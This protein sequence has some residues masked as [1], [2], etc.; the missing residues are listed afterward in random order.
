M[1]PGSAART[2]SAMNVHD[3]AA[4]GR[5]SRPHRRPAGP[6]AREQPPGP[7]PPG[8]PDQ[9]VGPD[10]P[11]RGLVGRLLLGGL[12]ATASA[13]PLTVLTAL[14][15]SRSGALRDWDTSIVTAVHDQVVVRP[16]LGRVLGWL[17]VVTHPNTVRGATAVLVVGLWRGGHRR[18]AA[19]LAATITLGGALDPLLKDSVERAR[20]VFDHPVALAPGYSFPSGH[21]LNTMLLAAC[22]V[23]LAHGP[24]HGRPLRRAAVWTGAVLLVLVT[25]ADRVGLGVHYTTDVLAGWLVALLTVAITTTAFESWRRDAGLTPSSPETGLDPDPGP[26]PEPGPAPGA[27]RSQP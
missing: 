17:S 13:V 4:L 14:V 7:H 19:W 16:T 26:A 3:L 27:R 2:M 10:H 25:G 20:P 24:T 9:P 18:R 5:R 15:L 8:R 12:V 21:A 22:L 1:C 23:L 11:D 6:T